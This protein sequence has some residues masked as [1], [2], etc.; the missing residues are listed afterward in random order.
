[1]QPTTLLDLGAGA[2]KYGRMAREHVPGCLNTAVEIDPGAADDLASKVC[3]DAVHHAEAVDWLVTN[4]GR[5]FD[6][7]VLGDCLHLMP[8]SQGMDL[9]HALIYRCA[10]VMILVPEFAANPGLAAPAQ[11]QPRSVW[12]ERDF[13]WADRWA[14]DNCRTIT[15][16]LLRG[17]QPAPRPLEEAVRALNQARLPV[18]DFDGVTPVR[19]ARLRMVEHPR[20]VNYRVY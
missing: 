12:S 16:V 5:V 14:W 3:Y 4:G 2:G 20:E 9:L 15:W 11:R 6:L 7:A 17:Y 18:L 10:W 13:H 19:P 1:M 8:R